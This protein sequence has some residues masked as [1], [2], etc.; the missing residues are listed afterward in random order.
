MAHKLREWF[1][2]NHQLIQLLNPHFKTK[3]EDVKKTIPLI[4]VPNH[5]HAWHS[6]A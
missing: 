3:K 4:S 6:R 1:T 5:L 2:Q